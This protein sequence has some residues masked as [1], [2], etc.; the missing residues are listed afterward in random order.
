MAYGRADADAAVAVGGALAGTRPYFRGQWS[1][2][3]TGP[4][5]V[6]L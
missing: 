5:L 3:A 1:A 2:P 4:E 6:N